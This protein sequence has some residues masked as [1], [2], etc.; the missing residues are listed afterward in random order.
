MDILFVTPEVA[1]YSKVGGLADISGA[2]PKALRGLGHRVTVFSPLH[3]CVDPS[4]HSLARRLTKLVVPMGERRFECALY[5]GRTAAGVDLLFLGEPTLFDRPGIYDDPSTR[6]RYEDDALRWA[7]FARAAL[8]LAR[9]R[10]GGFDVLHAHDWPSAL[11]PVYLRHRYAGDPRLARLGTVVSIHNLVHQGRFPR[12]TMPELDL[13]GSLFT[14][15]GLELFGDVSFLKGGLVYGDR[16]T[17]ASPTY[18]REIV[19]EEA[20]LGLEG[21]LRQRGS[22]LVGILNGIDQSIWNPATDPSLVSRYDA[23]SPGAK[24]RCKADLQRRL[25]LPVE[26][27][28]PLLGTVSRLAWEKGL[29]VLAKALERLLRADVQVAVLGKGEPAQEAAFRK[30][31]DQWRDRMVYVN[32]V[33]EP[34]AHQLYAGADLFVMPSRFEPCGLAQMY[35]QRYGTPPI[36]HAT[37]GLIDTVVDC[38]AHLETGTGF[39]FQDETPTDLVAAMRRA[40]AAYAQ[41]ELFAKLVRRVMKLDH[42]WDRSARRYETVYKQVL[43]EAVA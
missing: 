13:D 32:E 12:T 39:V 21:V 26:P 30:L 25:G 22:A 34:L 2:L 16:L 33:P 19:R 29:D 15:E 43:K 28:L 18:A 14:L 41:P 10:E 20:G 35:A 24:G 42:G 37:G 40:L 8:E 31:A 11:A 9:T 7:V 5:D 1:P 23:E 38:D 36:V 3:H 17:T 6:R 27:R 4:K